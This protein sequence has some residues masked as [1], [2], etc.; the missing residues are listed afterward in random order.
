MLANYLDMC[1]I[2]LKNLHFILAH[3]PSLL[4]YIMARLLYLLN[5]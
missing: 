4:T 1:E 2:C 5:M 3:K